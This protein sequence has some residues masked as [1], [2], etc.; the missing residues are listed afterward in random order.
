M[1]DERLFCFALS[2]FYD[3]PEAAEEISSLEH[4]YFF[5]EI[6]NVDGWERFALRAAHQGL[7]LDIATSNAR[8]LS[9]EILGKLSGRYFFK[10]ILP[11]SF[12]EYLRAS[13]IHKR[14]HA[15]GEKGT[16]ISTL[17]D[18]FVYGGFPESLSFADKRGCASNVFQ[19]VLYGDIVARQRIRN[20][21]G[22][23]LLIKK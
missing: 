22:L 21:N 18:Y 14:C 2:D 8:M 20:E 4:F 13:L 9:K 6:Q 3:I 16:M 1:G 19:K 11:Y 23:K 5:D 12:K 10:E 7:R 15:A 17:R